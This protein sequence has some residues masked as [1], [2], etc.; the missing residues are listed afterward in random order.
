MFVSHTG[1]TMREGQCHQ[2]NCK[3]LADSTP[4]DFS[5]VEINSEV[6]SNIYTLVFV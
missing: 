5:D 6:C 4:K 3:K 1:N 2:K